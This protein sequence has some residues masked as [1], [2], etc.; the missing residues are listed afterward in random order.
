MLSKDGFAHRLKLEF[1]CGGVFGRSR[2]ASGTIKAT[3]INNKHIP[4]QYRE[5]KENIVNYKVL[6]DLKHGGLLHPV[7]N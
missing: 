6:E 1:R 2:D 3:F 4:L 5:I 7:N